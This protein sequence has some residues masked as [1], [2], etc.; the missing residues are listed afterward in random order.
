MRTSFFY[1]CI[2]AF[3]AT[4]STAQNSI[5]SIQQK[6]AGWQTTSGLSNA[7]I[8]VSV[9]DLQTNKK[10]IESN[11]Q[12]SLI[13][14][15]IL[16]T[17]TT[18]TALEV[19]GAD[20]RFQTTL[21]YSGI[22]RNDTL[23]GDLQII[24][25]GDPT[26]G[27]EYFPE[28][29]SFLEE[30]IK[31]L[32]EKNIKAITGNLIV[33]A[34]IYESQTIPGT[35]IWEDIGNYF[36]AGASGISVYDNMYEIH[37]KSGSEAGK[38]TQIVQIVPEI[39]NLELSNEVLSSESN[40]DEAYIFGNPDENKRVVRGSIPKN[41]PDFIVKASV[42]NPSALLSSEFRKKLTASQIAILGETKFEK[43]KTESSNLLLVI[44]SPPLRDIIRVTNHESVN[45]FA[46]HFLKHLAFQK[47]GLGTTKDGCK[48]V[49]QF[50]KDK[51]LDMNG[52]YINDGSGLSRFNTITAS[53]MVS[54]LNYMKTKSPYSE[55]FY[56][57]LP[58]A[59]DG[60]LSKFSQQDFPDKCLRAKSGSMTRVRCY[61][62]YLNTLSGR[63]LSFA[64]MLNNF[65]CS[66]KEATR[67]IEEV[68]V[69]L[70]KM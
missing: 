9:F 7:S 56:Q 54:V 5:N 27:S 23:L 33:D 12:L 57:S 44:Q 25:G 66:Q 64:I 70:R 48:F 18:S 3:W 68:L 37:L 13:P 14:A 53:Q 67:K 47:N 40:S 16:K 59:G 49:M 26:L 22:V 61:A 20:F 30:W 17:I 19:F 63:Q 39:P 51:E 34:T 31:A 52:L 62:G 38:P 46:E 35:W 10:L 42:P 21:A 65:S 69:E 6:I 28:R 36:G 4:F 24:G 43:V 41:Q 11:P 1:A 55:D 58:S 15:S 45:L 32:K 8:C 60:T 2:F 29:K 50:W